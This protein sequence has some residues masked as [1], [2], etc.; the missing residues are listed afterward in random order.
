[1]SQ[2]QIYLHTWSPP[3]Y[4][5]GSSNSTC[6]GVLPLSLAWSP[7]QL[8][9][10]EVILNSSSSYT[11]DPRFWLFYLNI[12]QTISCLNILC[13][14]YP[15]ISPLDSYNSLASLLSSACF[16][17]A[18]KHKCTESMSSFKPA[19]FSLICILDDP[20]SP[21]LSTPHYCSSF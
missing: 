12:C 15:Y 13:F 17:H 19:L 8:G 2:T 10:L 1:M 21:G 18:V 3:R 11:T 16:I 4:T 5:I 20:S 6:Q 14:I 7:T 9:N